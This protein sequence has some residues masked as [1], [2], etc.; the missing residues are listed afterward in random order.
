[1]TYS[2]YRWN[3]EKGDGRVYCPSKQ[4]PPD[5]IKFTNEISD[6]DIN[7]LD[8]TLFKGERVNKQAS[9]DIRGHFKSTET[10]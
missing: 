1:M 9:L 3:V 6:K 7:F 10:F 4:S 2:C 5:P 8:T